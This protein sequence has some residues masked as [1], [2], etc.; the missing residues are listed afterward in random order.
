MKKFRCLFKDEGGCEIS[1]TP[2]EV[3]AADLAHAM[4]KFAAQVPLTDEVS[5]EIWEVS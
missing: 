5:V 1:Y 4:Q 3:E 2:L